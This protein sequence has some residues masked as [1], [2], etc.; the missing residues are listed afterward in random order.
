[1]SIT[2]SQHNLNAWTLSTQDKILFN[3]SLKITIPLSRIEYKILT[4]FATSPGNPISNEQTAQHL[5]KDIE[6]YKGLFMCVSRLQKKFRSFTSGD[7]IFRAARNRGYCIVQKI[8]LET[9]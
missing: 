1:M 9:L 3:T 6:Q 7:K 8:Q 5:G 2:E 4:L